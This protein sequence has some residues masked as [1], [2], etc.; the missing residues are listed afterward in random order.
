MGGSIELRKLDMRYCMYANLK[1]H[2][3]V[4]RTTEEISDEIR[5]G[6]LC[7]PQINCLASRVAWLVGLWADSDVVEQEGGEKDKEFCS[8]V[9]SIFSLYFGSIRIIEL[10]K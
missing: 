3:R 9:Y 4:E 2:S 1:V 7:V 8:H 10:E 5:L 6:H